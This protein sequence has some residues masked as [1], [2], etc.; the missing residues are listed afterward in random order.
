MEL[1][2][3]FSKKFSECWNHT[4]E[5]FY[6][7]ISWNPPLALWLYEIAPLFPINDCLMKSENIRHKNLAEK[8]P[9]DQ[10][11]YEVVL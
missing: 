8:I 9:K 5:Q 2:A 4:L 7:K 3:H 11:F 10:L 1:L 6:E